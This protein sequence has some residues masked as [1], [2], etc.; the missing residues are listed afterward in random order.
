MITEHQ[1]IFEP[2]SEIKYQEIETRKQEIDEKRKRRD[3]KKSSSEEESKDDQDCKPIEVETYYGDLPS[4][5]TE[6][7]DA[8]S[9]H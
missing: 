9:N 6:Y 8:M 5:E 7:H 3:S 1:R 4:K 2:V